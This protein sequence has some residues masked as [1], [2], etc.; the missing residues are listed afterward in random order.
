MKERQTVKEQKTELEI[1]A[2]RFLDLLYKYDYDG[3][4]AYF[5]NPEYD[6]LIEDRPLFN[7]EDS[8]QVITGRKYIWMDAPYF[9]MGITKEGQLFMP[10]KYWSFGYLYGGNIENFLD[11]DLWGRDVIRIH[12]SERH[13]TGG[14]G[15]PY[16]SATFDY[17]DLV[18]IRNK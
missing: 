4:D 11:P 10:K 15:V 2:E 7:R 3:D 8:Y 14:P 18:F 1:K 9:R 5:R 17:H 12:R 6:L 16:E 13:G